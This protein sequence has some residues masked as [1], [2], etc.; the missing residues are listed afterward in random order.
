MVRMINARDSLYGDL[1]SEKKILAF[2]SRLGSSSGH[3][4]KSQ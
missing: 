1:G 4:V 2:V 3:S